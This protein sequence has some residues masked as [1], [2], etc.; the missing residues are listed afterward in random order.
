[1]PAVD[2]KPSSPVQ[3]QR[4]RIVMAYLQPER[5]DALADAP[6]LHECQRL[7]AQSPSAPRFFDK[8]LVQKRE[9]A[10]ELEAV[11]IV[12]TKYPIA[13]LSA[14]MS[15]TPP[16]SG[17]SSNSSIAFRWRSRSN[18]SVSATYILS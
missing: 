4:T 15:Q 9:A 17:L 7:R 6:V 3:R 1:M 8:Q 10:A 11:S 16:C 14:S 12:I 18:E 2:L 5:V 13:A